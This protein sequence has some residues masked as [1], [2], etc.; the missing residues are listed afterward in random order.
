MKKIY[1]VFWDFPPFSDGFLAINVS[2]IHAYPSGEAK[3]SIHEI[4]RYGNIK[5]VDSC[6]NEMDD[7]AG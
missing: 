1:L 3:H 4:H 5:F 7:N 2:R 6:C